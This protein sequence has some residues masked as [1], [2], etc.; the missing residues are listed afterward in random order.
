MMYFNF[1]RVM[2]FYC[3]VM[4]VFLNYFGIYKVIYFYGEFGSAI[5]VEGY[6]NMYGQY[7]VWYYYWEDGMLSEFVIYSDGKMYGFLIIWFPNGQ[8]FKEGDYV[9]GEREGLWVFWQED[10]AVN[11][12][13]S[14]IYKVGDR[15]VFFFNEQE[16]EFY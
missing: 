1:D 3:D 16:Q 4:I 8:K 6:V 2:V 9:N 7:C 13:C 10:G 14:G 15:I 12:E 5:K 11:Y